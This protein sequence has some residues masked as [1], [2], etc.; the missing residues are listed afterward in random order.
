L[1]L[2]YLINCIHSGFR[3]LFKNTFNSY[4]YPS[5]YKLK[6]VPHY[7]KSYNTPH[8][9]QNKW[10]LV[11]FG[12]CHDLLTNTLGALIEQKIYMIIYLL[13]NFHCATLTENSFS[14]AYPGHTSPA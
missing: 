7:L 14:N 1:L 2:N 3:Q 6:S 11:N 12:I 10:M 4:I 13:Y 9:F 5:V 8:L